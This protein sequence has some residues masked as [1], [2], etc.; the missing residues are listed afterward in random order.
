MSSITNIFLKTYNLWD[1]V[2]AAP[3]SPKQTNDRYSMSNQYPQPSTHQPRAD[4]YPVV[5]SLRTMDSKMT[6]LRVR[7]A[8]FL[9]NYLPDERVNETI[10]TAEEFNDFWEPGAMDG[11]PPFV[12]N[13]NCF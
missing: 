6:G 7:F 3:M 1:M 4:S 11:I 9:R 12:M 2:P 5:S 13:C 8:F 10:A